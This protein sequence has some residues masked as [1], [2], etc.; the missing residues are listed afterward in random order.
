MIKKKGQFYID[1]ENWGTSIG[2][3]SSNFK[4][5]IKEF[6]GKG[7]FKNKSLYD[8]I[9]GHESFGFKE[10]NLDFLIDFKKIKH[11]WLWD[12][13]LDNI[14]GIYHLK[15]V[16]TFGVT[17]KRPPIDF[18]K[19]PNIKTVTLDW[20]TKDYN[21]E[22]CKSIENFHLWHHKPKEK[23]FMNIMF[24]PNCSNWF[25]LN[26]TNVEDLSTLNGLKGIRKIGIH[27][28]RNLKSLQG[29]ERYIDTLEEVI[30]TTSGKLTEF[31]FLK[32]FPK[33]K[34]LYINEKKYK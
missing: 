19:F 33:L 15:D 30:V 2:I 13:D 7:I 28:S 32:N 14:E 1:N 6:K 12:V 9:F 11:I 26:W 25:S 34:K 20:E 18:G 27:R 21:L 31:E 23:N 24:P 5:C 10:R 3:D 29:L 17:G 4:N 22:K 16:E 8:G